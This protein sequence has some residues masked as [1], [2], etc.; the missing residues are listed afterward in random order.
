MMQ[1]WHKAHN[2]RNIFDS[3][4]YSFRFINL[5]KKFIMLIN[6]LSD[7]NHTPK[8]TVFV[9]RRKENTTTAISENC[10]VRTKIIPIL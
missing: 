2:V 1:L 3:Y 10:S 5:K 9:V 6:D 4:A 7:S 8:F